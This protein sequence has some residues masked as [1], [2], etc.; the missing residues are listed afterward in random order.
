MYMM[1]IV[2][3]FDARSD[4]WRVGYLATNKFDNINSHTIMIERDT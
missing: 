3:H 2:G 4:L 1:I